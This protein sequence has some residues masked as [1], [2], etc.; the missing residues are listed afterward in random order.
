MARSSGRQGGSPTEPRRLEG[1]P[2]AAFPE[3]LGM[4]WKLEN[5]GH[6]KRHVFTVQWTNPENPINKGLPP[7]FV[8]NDELYHKIDLKPNATVI[9]TAYDDPNVPG[10]TGK[11]EP[12]IWTVPFG[13]GRVVMM[14]LGHDLLAMSQPGF[15]DA[16]VRG[17]EWSA[18]G[19][20]SAGGPGM[21]PATSMPT[22]TASRSK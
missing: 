16:L 9:A 8:A 11:T 7:T 21:A 5:I 22:P 3:M 15:M 1:E 17:T 10:G 12:V 14:V 13:Q 2:W 6:A 20:V 4:T 19:S 18:T